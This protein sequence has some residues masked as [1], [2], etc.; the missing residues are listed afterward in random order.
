MGCC[1]Q[2]PL[3]LY[4]I[5]RLLHYLLEPRPSF[6][7]VICE[8][9]LCCEPSSLPLVGGMEDPLVASPP[10]HPAQIGIVGFPWGVEPN[11]SNRYF[12]LELS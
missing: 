1:T 11:R 10:A 4:F 6:C 5:L 2:L 7:R 12:F 3:F 9:Q 8:S